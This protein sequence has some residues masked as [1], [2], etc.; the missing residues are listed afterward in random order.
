MVLELP[1]NRFLSLLAVL[2]QLVSSVFIQATGSSLPA[3]AQRKHS[4]ERQ[5]DNSV[6]H[7]HR[8]TRQLPQAALDASIHNKLLRHKHYSNNSRLRTSRPS[9]TTDH[10][11]PFPPAAPFSPRCKNSR[12]EVK[13]KTKLISARSK[14]GSYKKIT[15]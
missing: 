4:K 13:K 6:L 1:P 8:G 12:S 5:L 10:L 14:K 9:A 3:A 15:N 7:Y 2:N 11:Q